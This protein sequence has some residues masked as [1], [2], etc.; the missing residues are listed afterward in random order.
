M[1]KIM[2]RT[3]NFTLNPEYH[4]EEQHEVA[5]PVHI[6]HRTHIFSHGPRL[7]G[8]TFYAGVQAPTI[9]VANGQ[10][11]PAAFKKAT[12]G[13]LIII[14]LLHTVRFGDPVYTI[15]TWAPLQ[16]SQ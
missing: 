9:N 1:T 2:T 14:P 15:P 10:C 4:K 5:I 13:K 8:E 6:N 12:E 3:T 16:M 7:P 11:H